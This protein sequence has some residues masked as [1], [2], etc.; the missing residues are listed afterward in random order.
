MYTDA[1]VRHGRDDDVVGAGVMRRERA[2]ERDRGARGR[3]GGEVVSEPVKL[4]PHYWGI[5]V[6]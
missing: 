1:R 5:T 4:K 6:H 2:R 3:A